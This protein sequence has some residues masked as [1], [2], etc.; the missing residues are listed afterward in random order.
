MSYGAELFGSGGNLIADTN[1]PVFQKL[2]TKT[3]GYTGTRST[4]ID[5]NGVSRTRYTYHYPS[6]FPE[7]DPSIGDIMF[8]KM[9]PGDATDRAFKGDTSLTFCSSAQ[10]HDFM[11]ARVANLLAPASYGMEV[12]NE[13]GVKC[14]TSSDAI[15][16]VR[17]VNGFAAADT[18]DPS[19]YI[20]RT[21]PDSLCEWLAFDGSPGGPLFGD[22]SFWYYGT[23][24]VQRMDP[25]TWKMG[26]KINR[27]PAGYF[28]SQRGQTCVIIAKSI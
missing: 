25:L 13:N 14:F 17:G 2:V 4:F 5:L 12:Y 1:Y 16:D 27:F 22:P 18:T 11:V 6:I 8:V 20:T 23:P 26:A 28:F 3:L 24:I 21:V 10:Q 15:V 7:F 9:A 19:D